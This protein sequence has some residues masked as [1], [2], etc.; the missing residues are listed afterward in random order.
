MVNQIARATVYSFDILLV[1]ILLGREDVGFYGAA[2][3]PVLFLSG[4][5]GLFYISF[6]TSYATASSSHAGPL[7]RRTVGQRR[8]DRPDRGLGAAL[9]P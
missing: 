7:F 8:R 5:L 9:S 2:T 3:K 1:A 6:L 4:A